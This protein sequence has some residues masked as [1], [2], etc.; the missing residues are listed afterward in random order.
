MRKWRRCYVSMVT[1][2]ICGYVYVPIV[3]D[4]YADIVYVYGLCDGSS[5]HAVAEYERRF[6]N[7][8]IPYR[9]VFTVYGLGE[10]LGAAE[11]TGT[12]SDRNKIDSFRR[13]VIDN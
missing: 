12:A 1:K 6:P 9:R 13:L 11:R 2:Y 7:R 4:E 5:L 10:R 8:R 3:N